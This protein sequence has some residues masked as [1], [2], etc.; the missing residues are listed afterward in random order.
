[1]CNLY[2][3]YMGIREHEHV[4]ISSTFVLYMATTVYDI[5]QCMKVDI[6]MYEK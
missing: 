4:T 5:E 3:L 2:A 1:M 6:I